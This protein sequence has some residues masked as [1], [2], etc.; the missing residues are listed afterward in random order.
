MSNKTR[1]FL[2]AVEIAADALDR[3]D[4]TI[5]EIADALTVEIEDR[6][7]EGRVV[8]LADVSESLDVLVAAARVGLEGA[9]APDREIEEAE[10]ALEAI[11]AR[12]EEGPS[13]VDHEGERWYWRTFSPGEG[14][15]EAV[16]AVVPND[17]D[18][19]WFALP[20]TAPSGENLE[21]AVAAFH[22]TYCVDCR[23]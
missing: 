16:V 2:V 23:P 15:A 10:I 7:I 3:A 8:A 21:I 11:E 20:G 17:P 19:A 12:F 13:F 5:S 14:K 22:A 9:D 18:A 4:L 6:M 1:T